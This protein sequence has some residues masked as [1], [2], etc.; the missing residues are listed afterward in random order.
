MIKAV[1]LT[2]LIYIAFETQLLN[3]QKRREAIDNI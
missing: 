1:F 3:T 2:S